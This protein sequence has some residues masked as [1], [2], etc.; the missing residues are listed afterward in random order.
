MSLSPIHL[1]SQR[2]LHRETFLSEDSIRNNPYHK[3]VPT[4]I[5]FVK[6]GGVNR[7]SFDGSTSKIDTGSS[8]IPTEYTMR[9]RINATALGEG[10][11]GTI[12]SDGQSFVRL[13]TSGSGYKIR[14][15]GNSGTN[16][17]TIGAS[18]FVFGTEYELVVTRTAAAS[19]SVYIN[20]VFNS[21]ATS[22]NIVAGTTNVII[23]N[24]TGGTNTF[25][26]TIGLFDFFK[27]AF[28]ASEV[29]N[30]YSNKTYVDSVAKSQSQV[31]GSDLLAGWDF[32]NWTTTGATIN[33]ATQFTSTTGGIFKV[34]VTVGT[35]YS[36]T[37]A[38]TTANP[39]EVRSTSGAIVYTT[40]SGTFN[41]TFTFTA[42]QTD[43]YLRI[44][45]G[46][47]ATI[48]TLTLKTI[49]Q[50]SGSQ[51]ADFRAFDGVI[52]D[53]SGQRTI[54]NTSTTVKQYGSL[55]VI[56]FNGTTSKL[57]TGADYLGTGDL[58]V[59]GWIYARS[60]G[61]GIVGRILTNGKF[62]FRLT[63]PRLLVSSDNSTDK[64]SD[65]S[66]IVYG[67]WQFVVATRTANGTANIY[68]G[69]RNTAPTL[70]GTANQSSGTPVAGTSNVIV[71]NDTGG[72]TTFDGYISRLRPWSRIL[73]L[74]EITQMWSA[75]KQK[76]Q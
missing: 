42:V 45:L 75:S 16:A 13:I 25:N 17:Q 72:S 6:S 58:T 44:A 26:G 41:S 60:A 38:G 22:S 23:G 74:A 49:T 19:Y 9:C 62:V 40:V 76:Y 18:D 4:T 37:I 8:W 46:G 27:G 39:L 32:N 66:S 55:N 36:M 31:L 69:N 54:T 30:L 29:A 15:S 51:L 1:D 12:F 5:T 68:I 14:V 48:T 35:R 20:G 50:E 47:Q 10:N 59:A 56:D 65:A 64:L 3:G 34:L 61:E 73:S 53:K 57:D 70:N 11:A 63:G 28:T 52:A 67:T 24:N 21:S 43:I 7:G 2:I 33:N 71:G